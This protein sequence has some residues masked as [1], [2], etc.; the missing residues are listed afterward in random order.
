MIAAPKSIESVT[1]PLA[2][3]LSLIAPAT[4]AMTAMTERAMSVLSRPASGGDARDRRL[5][6]AAKSPYP[7]AE[8]ERVNGDEDRHPIER[9]RD[10]ECGG[11][12]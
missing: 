5:W 10:S 2:P 11:S 1:T 8:D 12:C 6:P 9:F 7:Q 3:L 4:A